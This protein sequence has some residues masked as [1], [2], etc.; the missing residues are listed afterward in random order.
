METNPN[1]MLPAA[2]PMLLLPAV[3]ATARALQRR[4]ARAASG[5]RAAAAWTAW[6]LS[7][8]ATMLSERKAAREAA[9]RSVGFRIRGNPPVEI[10]MGTARPYLQGESWR[11]ETPSGKPVYHPNAYRRAYGKPVY[12]RSTRRIVVG[13][14]W[15]M[16]R[17]ARS[18]GRG[19]CPACS[20]WTR[21]GVPP[22]ETG[23]ICPKCDGEC[24]MGGP[25]Q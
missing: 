11:Y 12:V 18:I 8:A 4:A 24:V 2:R 10:V 3:T 5:E 17:R 6:V 15:L 25:H 22:D 14:A 20:A 23:H 7:G 1:R 9:S 13:A 16:S 19:W 21:D